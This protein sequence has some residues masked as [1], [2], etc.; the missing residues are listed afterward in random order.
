MATFS[1]TVVDS[2]RGEVL[3]EYTV[4]CIASVAVTVLTPLELPVWSSDLLLLLSAVTAN[5]GEVVK[6]ADVVF[7]RVGPE[8]CAVPSPSSVIVLSSCVTT[9]PVPV[10]SVTVSAPVVTLCP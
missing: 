10:P 2:T 1:W 8:V 9:V 3:T 4:V 6:P 5:T 7:A